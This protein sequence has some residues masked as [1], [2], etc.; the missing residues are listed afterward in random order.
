MYSWRFT[1][2]WQQKLKCTNKKVTV[3][4]HKSSKRFS[5]CWTIFSAILVNLQEYIFVQ[6]TMNFAFCLVCRFFAFAF[7]IFLYWFTHPIINFFFF[8]FFFSF[9][10]NL[11]DWRRI[12][13]YFSSLNHNLWFTKWVDHMN[14]FSLEMSCLTESVWWHLGLRISLFCE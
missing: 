7:C 10:L 12:F 3:H 2:G 13:S 9:K 11:L 6:R 5:P 4:T 8:F 14:W 1:W